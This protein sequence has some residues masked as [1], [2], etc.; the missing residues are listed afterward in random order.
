M[1]ADASRYFWKRVNRFLMIALS[2]LE[3]ETAR[4]L[5]FDSCRF[6]GCRQKLSQLIDF[7]EIV[8]ISERPFSD[9]RCVVEENCSHIWQKAQNVVSHN[10]DWIVVEIENLEFRD[11]PEEIR[12]QRFQVVLFHDQESQSGVVQVVGRNGFQPQARQKQYR[13]AR[14][15][16]FQPFRQHRDV[17]VL[18]SKFLDISQWLIGQMVVGNSND[19]QSEITSVRQL[20]ATEV[21]VV[22]EDVGFDAMDSERGKLVIAFDGCCFERCNCKCKWNQIYHKCPEIEFDIRYLLSST[23]ISTYIAGNFLLLVALT[24]SQLLTAAKLKLSGFESLHIESNKFSFLRT[25]RCS[26]IK[27]C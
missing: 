3:R 7:L 22:H 13:N 2:T 14:E 17:L 26:I 10:R 8:E 12:T 27:S 1:A 19:A 18:Q 25:I 6:A 24:L 20:A 16:L 23:E 9:A 21:D 4:T 15:E 5:I 11:V